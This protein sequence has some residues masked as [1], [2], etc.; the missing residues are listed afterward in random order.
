MAGESKVQELKFG[1]YVNNI[2]LSHL[3]TGGSRNLLRG[4]TKIP[5]RKLRSKPAIEEMIVCV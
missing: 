1:K 2:S 5:N 4:Q 3:H